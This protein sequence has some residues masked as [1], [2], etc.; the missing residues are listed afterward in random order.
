MSHFSLRALPWGWI[1]FR[2][3]FEVPAE[4]EL[5]WAVAAVLPFPLEVPMDPEAQGV[6]M[7]CPHRAVVPGRKRFPG[8]IKDTS[9]LSDTLGQ[10]RV[11]F[12]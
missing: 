1:K 9:S 12:N 5:G 10:S 11:K 4:L 7:K 3:H 8:A 6:L 2:S